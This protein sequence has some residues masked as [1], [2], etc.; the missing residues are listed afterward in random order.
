MGLPRGRGVRGWPTG[1]TITWTWRKFHRL[2][3]QA[4]IAFVEEQRR[5]EK[6][7]KRIGEDKKDDAK[8]KDDEPKLKVRIGSHRITLTQPRSV[9]GALCDPQCALSP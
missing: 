4:A 1:K 6:K 2:P 7:R 3:L 9:R 8:D 5:K